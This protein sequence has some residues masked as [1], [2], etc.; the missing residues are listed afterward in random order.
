MWTLDQ[1]VAVVQDIEPGIRALSYHTLL[2][3]SVLHDGRSDKDLDLFFYPLNGSKSDPTKVLQF[4]YKKF[5]PSE[6]LRDSPD[7]GA[8][9]ALTTYVKEMVKYTVK[10][11]RIDVFIR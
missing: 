9:D 4:L 11:K 1:A 2:G 10:G 6:A 3:G 8:E 7:Y 5:G